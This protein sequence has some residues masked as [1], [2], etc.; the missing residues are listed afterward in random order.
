VHD[1][2]FYFRFHVHLKGN[3]KNTK[4]KINQYVLKLSVFEKY[5]PIFLDASNLHKE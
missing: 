4:F 1:I 2:Y 3:K 5:L